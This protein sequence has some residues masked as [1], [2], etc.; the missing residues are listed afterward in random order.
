MSFIGE[1]VKALMNFIGLQIPWR[2][3]V[4]VCMAVLLVIAYI[5][6][7]DFNTG[8]AAWARD[9]QCKYEQ[10]F[11]AATGGQTMPKMVVVRT[12]NGCILKQVHP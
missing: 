6:R 5:D 4:P 11:S 7:A 1:I 9:E 10:I 12:H 3:L 8:V 2:R